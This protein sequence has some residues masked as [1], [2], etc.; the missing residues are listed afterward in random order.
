MGFATHGIGGAA[1]VG[2]MAG[3]GEAARRISHNITR[4][5]A[6]DF[7]ELVREGTLPPRGRGF[8]NPAFYGG[9]VSGGAF[10]YEPAQSLT[11][12]D[13]APLQ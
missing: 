9:Q 7:D 1:V 4:R 12:T 13:P 10:N 8:V 6:T 5:K 2:G 3:I 11:G